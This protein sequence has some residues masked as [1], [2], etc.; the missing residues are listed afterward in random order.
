MPV[1]FGIGEY[2]VSHQGVFEIGPL[3]LSSPTTVVGPKV[4][5]SKASSFEVRILEV[6]SSE[7][8]VLQVHS[9]KIRS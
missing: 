1:I 3:Q 7:Y 6:G 8:R 5:S 4:G 9:G 2:G